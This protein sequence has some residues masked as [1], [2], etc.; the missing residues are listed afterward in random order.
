MGEG[1]ETL[2]CQVLSCHDWRRPGQPGLLS[3]GS[4]SGKERCR[5]GGLSQCRCFSGEIA[6]GTVSIRHELESDTGC[7]ELGSLQT[8]SSRNLRSPAVYQ[9]TG[10]ALA[11]LSPPF[12]RSS[13]LWPSVFP[14][15][16][17]LAVHRPG[18]E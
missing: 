2:K 10:P 14:G 11:S 15:L 6:G 8:Q 5:G 7:A 3:W 18:Q 4:G 12:L 16:P 1:D 17:H 13:P 9:G